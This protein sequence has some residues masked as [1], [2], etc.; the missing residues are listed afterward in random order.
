MVS[1][2]TDI[3]SDLSVFHHK[4]VVTITTQNE[5][6]GDF[7]GRALPGGR[8]RWHEELRRVLLELFIKFFT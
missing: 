2:A 4:K 7:S 8:Q 5:S 6:F 3:K 1:M